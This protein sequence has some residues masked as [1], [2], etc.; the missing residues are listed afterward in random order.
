MF[1]PKIRFFFFS[2]LTFLW[3]QTNVAYTSDRQNKV[4]HYKYSLSLASNWFVTLYCK[5][6]PPVSSASKHGR[7]AFYYTLYPHYL[8]VSSIPCCIANHLI[9]TLYWFTCCGKTSV[10]KQ[11]SKKAENCKTINPGICPA[12]CNTAYISLTLTMLYHTKIS[13][14]FADGD[15]QSP[16]YLHPWKVLPIEA[17]SPGRYIWIIYWVGNS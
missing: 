8:C 11:S 5:L 7:L 13:M 4:V 6:L 15:W 1:T 2:I 14:N 9:T 12:S 16:T 17:R 10:I 3:I